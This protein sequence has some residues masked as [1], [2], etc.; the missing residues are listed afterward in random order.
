MPGVP[1][2]LGHDRMLIV[3]IPGFTTEVYCSGSSSPL[4]GYPLRAPRSCPGPGRRLRGH[5]VAALP[6]ET[7]SAKYPDGGEDH[8]SEP[9]VPGERRAAAVAIGA[10]AH[11]VTESLT[12][13]WRPAGLLGTAAGAPRALRHHVPQTGCAVARSASA[14][15][16]F[17]L[18]VRSHRPLDNGGGAA[19]VP[20]GG[21]ARCQFPGSRPRRRC[22]GRARPTRATRAPTCR[23]A[24]GRSFPSRRRWRRRPLRT[25]AAGS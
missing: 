19:T 23:R 4:P 22:T 11:S 2:L 13:E 12:T 7:M 24:A 21:N 17:T 20:E 10:P 18:S 8:I 1:W 3:A 9:A 6:R 25:P 5:D 15:A 14:L 16:N